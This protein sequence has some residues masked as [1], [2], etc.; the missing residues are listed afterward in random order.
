MIPETG[1]HFRQK[2]A[3]VL[4]RDQFM[5]FQ[6]GMSLYFQMTQ[7]QQLVRRSTQTN[8]GGGGGE[9]KE[10]DKEEEDKKKEEE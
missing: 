6:L 9:D 10:E 2:R 4:K 3:D 7:L 5:T 8:E 1:W